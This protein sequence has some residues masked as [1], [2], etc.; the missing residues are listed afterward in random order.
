MAWSYVAAR[1]SG[2]TKERR[3]PRVLAGCLVAPAATAP[4]KSLQIL[5]E[6][7]GGG[8]TREGEATMANRDCSSKDHDLH[9]RMD[10]GIDSYHSILKS[11][12]PREPS[13]DP[14]KPRDKLVSSAEERLDSAYESSSITVESL[15]ETVGGCTLSS[16][17]EEQTPS[18]DPS[19]DWN[20]LTTITEDGDT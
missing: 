8:G 11:E 9:D 5:G 17:T 2:L 10:S 1:S 18:S 3:F 13:C 15:S 4:A 7:R 19:E 20:L 12:E 6:E 14:I 16:S